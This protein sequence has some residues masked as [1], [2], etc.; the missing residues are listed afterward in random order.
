[1]IKPTDRLI[2]AIFIG[3][4]AGG[5]QTLNTLFDLLAPNFKIPIVTAVGSITARNNMIKKYIYSP[6]QLSKEP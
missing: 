2:E 6:H 5:V 3:T 1:M 4:S